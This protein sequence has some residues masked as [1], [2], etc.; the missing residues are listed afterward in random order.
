MGLFEKVERRKRKRADWMKWQVLT[1][2]DSKCVY[3]DKLLDL[4]TLTL[5]HFVP[6]AKSGINHISNLVPACA[7]CN[8]IKADKLFDSIS[9]A[10]E[11]IKLNPTT[12]KL[13]DLQPSIRPDPKMAEVLLF[14]VSDAKVVEV[15]PTADNNSTSNS[16]DAAREFLEKRYGKP[17]GV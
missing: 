8:F 10:R 11:Y 16:S 1:D 9:L 17:K 6:L 14:Q 7:L 2:Y 15:K 4:K 3:C 13:S 12:V 5:D